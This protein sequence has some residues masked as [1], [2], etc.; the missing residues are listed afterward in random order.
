M[1]EQTFK[2]GRCSCHSCLREQWAPATLR[3]PDLPFEQPCYNGP[4]KQGAEPTAPVEVYINPHWEPTEL[5]IMAWR[6]TV[7]V[8]VRFGDTSITQELRFWV[9]E[10]WQSMET[11]LWA[12][13][14][15]CCAIYF[16]DHLS[17]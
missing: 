15:R 6:V 13:Y 11:V 8:L 5:D 10:F 3:L 14:I 4:R 7:R 9:G 1:V 17:A 2:R 12:L 16:N